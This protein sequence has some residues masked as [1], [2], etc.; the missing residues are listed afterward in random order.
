MVGQML[1]VVGD[2]EHDGIH[3]FL[4]DNHMADPTR[5]PI[6]CSVASASTAAIVAVTRLP[7]GQLILLRGLV[8]RLIA[9]PSAKSISRR[10][11]T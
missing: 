8:D 4:I 7:V 9:C 10:D 5:F 2:H 6:G 11:R 1:L 3:Y